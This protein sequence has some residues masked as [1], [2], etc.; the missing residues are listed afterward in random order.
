M[1]ARPDAL[2]DARWDDVRLFLA[3]YRSRSL[4][5][6]GTRV[7]LDAS[8]LSRR[9]ASLEQSLGTRLFDRTRDGLAATDAAERL[10]SA[11]EEMEAAHARF[12]RDASGLERAAEGVVRLSVP[13]GVADAFVVPGLAR[14]RVRHP[15]IRIELDASVRV[16]DLTRREADLALRTI[17][18]G[19]GDLVMARLDASVW[20]PMIASN[21][22]ATRPAVKNWE[23]L[24]WIAWDNDLAGI[25]PA[26]WLAEHVP[27]LEPVLKTSHIAAQVAAVREGVGVALLPATYTRV[28]PILPLRH[29]PALAPSVRDL[30]TIETWLVGH[31][32]LRGVPRVAAVW[33]FLVEEFHAFQKRGRKAR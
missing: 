32:A 27:D 8:T 29:A 31:R 3:L 16:T 15:R 17:R 10:F 12:S 6:A 1:Q 5:A 7:A 9:L 22:A 33:D 19:S 4:A 24:P 26:R 14:L 20:T 21:G 2:S 23:E 30:P 11:A 25:P 13:P 28:E 18:P